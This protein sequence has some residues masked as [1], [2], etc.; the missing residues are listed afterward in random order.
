MDWKDWNGIF[1]EVITP[2]YAIHTHINSSTHKHTSMIYSK[3]AEAI[4]TFL[5]LLF[6]QG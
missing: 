4:I 5:L 1:Y 2:Q 6:F 3:E